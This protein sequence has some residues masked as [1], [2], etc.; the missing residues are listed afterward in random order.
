MTGVIVWQAAAIASSSP[1]CSTTAPS[2]SRRTSTAISAAASS[3]QGKFALNPYWSWGWDAIAE[4]RRHV[5]PLLRPR[6]QAQDRPNLAALSRGPARPE[7]CRACA[8]TRPATLLRTQ[9]SPCRRDGL[10]DHRL[11]LHLQEPDHRRRAQL[12]LERDGLANADGTDSNRL[13]DEAN[14]RRQMID[15]IGEVFTPFAQIRGDLYGVN[16]FVDPA[17][18]LKSSGALVRGIAVGGAEYRYPFIATTGSVAHVFEPI[19]QIIGRPDSV[20]IDQSEIPTRTR[21]ASF[22]TTPSC[23]TSTSSPATTAS[24]PAPAP[25]LACATPRNCRHGAYARAVFGESYQ[26]AGQNTFDDR[27]AASAPGPPTM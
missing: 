3:P 10:S 13:I 17:T 2:S 26:L 6:Q 20:G 11:R 25:M 5:P 21:R 14:W 9:R 23:S 4:T 12:Q 1:A 22:S 15:R 18:D 8:S 16:E 19:G 27:T 24:R 7:L